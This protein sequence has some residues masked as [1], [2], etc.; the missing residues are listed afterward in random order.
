MIQFPNDWVS[1][2]WLQVEVYDDKMDGLSQCNVHSSNNIIPDGMSYHHVKILIYW[3]EFLGTCII[4]SMVLVSCNRTE[5]VF[6]GLCE[7]SQTWVRGRRK[8]KALIIS[9][10]QSLSYDFL[11]SETEAL[12]FSKYEV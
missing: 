1:F 8:A 11:K 3:V 4:M 12:A 2:V 6:F 5:S 10:S 7:D 9:G